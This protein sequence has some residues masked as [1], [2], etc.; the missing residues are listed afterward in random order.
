MSL[1]LNP[2]A[3]IVGETL[4]GDSI[5]GHRV[6][7]T[8][9]SRT[10]VGKNQRLFA[11]LELRRPYSFVSNFFMKTR[12]QLSIT[13]PG[14]VRC[15]KISERERSLSRAQFRKKCSRCGE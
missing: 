12:A 3:W 9:F 10:E 15:Y 1:V 5:D 7:G 14:R 13:R 6:V 8:T 4:Y 2:F 11:I